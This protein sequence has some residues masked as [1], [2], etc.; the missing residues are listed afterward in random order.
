MQTFLS[1]I[2]SGKLEAKQDG[3]FISAASVCL[4]GQ[5][6]VRERRREGVQFGVISLIKVNKYSKKPGLCSAVL[7]YN[8]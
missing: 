6:C 3:L 1:D 2:R 4:T 5:V 8:R 7:S